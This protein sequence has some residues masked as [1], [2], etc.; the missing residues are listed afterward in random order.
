MSKVAVVAI[1]GNSL[2]K[3]D[4]HRSVPDQFAAT[5]ETALHITE[6]IK[7]GWDVVITH[8]N[9]P[10]VGFILLRSELASHIIHTVPLDSCGAD[11]Q[12]A[13][14][15]MIQQCLYNEFLRQGVPKQAATVVT[16]V[17]V[18]KDDPA[19][20]NPAKP[21]GPFY[22]E[23]KAKRYQAQ[24]HWVMREDAG[25]G[26]RRVVPS[27]RP[28]EIVERAAIQSLVASGYAVIAVGGGGVPVIRY[29]DGTLHGVEAVIDKDYASALLACTV[30]ADL[31]LISTAI[32]RVAINYRKPEQ[33]FLEQIT[34]SE[35][36]QYLAEGQFPAGSMGP[37]IEACIQ[38]VTQCGKEALI[39]SPERIADALAG[40][41][42]TRMTMG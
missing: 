6:M 3:D 16:Q 22:D 12:G 41:A 7:A 14:G 23:E 39:T 10:Q 40:R 29:E 24:R 42:G 9:G 35:A 19:F 26:W 13:L 20:S 33:R 38:F 4:Q 31:F 2:I 18:D 21:I 37:K 5:R 17:V 8:G 34:V 27:P 1:G 30:H 32:D 25:R 28:L 15:Y 11:T 36:T